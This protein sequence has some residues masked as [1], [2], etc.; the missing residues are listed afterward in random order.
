MRN[1]FC[2][3]SFLS[4]FSVFH[5]ISRS[6]ALLWIVTEVKATIQ[7]DMNT[8]FVFHKVRKVWEPATQLY[9]LWCFLQQTQKVFQL[10]AWRE[11]RNLVNC[12]RELNWPST[13]SNTTRPFWWSNTLLLL[14]LLLLFSAPPFFA[15]LFVQAV[16]ESLKEKENCNLS[17]AVLVFFIAHYPHTNMIIWSQH[18]FKKQRN[19]LSNTAESNN[20]WDM[21]SPGGRFCSTDINNG[22][23]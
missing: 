17:T 23:F 4:A 6:A 10:T 18:N 12:D 5:F 14:L 15:S 19:S 2:R 3:Q 8:Q 21:I 7:T 16:E 9:P 11:L 13:L 20:T 1:T 22:G